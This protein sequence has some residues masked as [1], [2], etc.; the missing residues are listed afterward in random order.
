MLK[1]KAIYILIGFI[2]LVLV[3][4]TIYIYIH[5]KKVKQLQLE[6]LNNA[7]FNNGGVP[8]T[9]LTNNLNNSTNDIVNKYKN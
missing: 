3:C 4:T 7:M 8:I 5:D 9:E 6:A 2:V 1:D